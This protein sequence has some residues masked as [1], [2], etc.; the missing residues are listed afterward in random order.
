MTL[1]NLLLLLTAKLPPDYGPMHYGQVLSHWALGNY[2]GIL[3]VVPIVLAV[4]QSARRYGWHALPIKTIESR[5]VLEGTF[6][7]IPAM[8]LLIWAGHAISQAR[9]I[10]Q[11][12]MFMP[13]VWLALR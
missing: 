6:L 7:L 12:A 2:L 1:N 8:L 13:M 9:E 4:N 11:M 5:L 10:A 3:T